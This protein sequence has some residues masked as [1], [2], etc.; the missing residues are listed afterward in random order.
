M[1]GFVTD[2]MEKIV[3]DKQN[4]KCA[5]KPG[6]NICGMTDYKCPLWQSNRFYQGE[7]DEL[8]YEIDY[9]T[10]CDSID[11]DNVNNLQAL[12]KVCYTIKTERFLMKD[13]K[14]KKCK[15]SDGVISNEK[16]K[17]K[18][19]HQRSIKNSTY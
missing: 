10:K 2:A 9:I 19:G 14:N 15:S 11:D 7:F 3:V 18:K 8:G 5:N 16:S 17:K 12:C 6:K 13:E 4:F 1:L